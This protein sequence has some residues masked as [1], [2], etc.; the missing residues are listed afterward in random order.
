MRT[1]YPNALKEPSTS[2]AKRK[3]CEVEIFPFSPEI[4]CVLKIL[5]KSR[6]IQ[7]LLSHARGGKIHKQ[8]DLR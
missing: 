8:P 1:L 2:F 4:C 6:Y 3:H 5:R 7:R